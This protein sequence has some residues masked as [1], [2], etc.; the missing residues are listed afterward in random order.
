MKNKN[1]CLLIN[2]LCLSAFILAHPRIGMTSCLFRVC[3]AWWINS[4]A[5]VGHSLSEKWLSFQCP[6]VT[7]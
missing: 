3:T 2:T 6:C 7:G 1:I 4:R 5:F